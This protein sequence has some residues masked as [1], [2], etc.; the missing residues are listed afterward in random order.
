MLKYDKPKILLMDLG[1]NVGDILRQDGFN[2]AS[3]SFGTPYKVPK[4]AQMQPIIACPTLPNYTEQEVVVVNLMPSSPSDSHFGE[5]NVPSDEWDWWGK[6]S[7]GV[8]DP[9][10]RAMLAV[11]EEMDRIL[12]SGGVF[13]IFADSMVEQDIAIGSIRQGSHF[14]IAR[15]FM[16]SNWS[17]LTILSYLNV[18]DDHGEE[19][20]LV[21]SEAPVAQVLKYHVD[22]A[23][24]SCTLKPGSIGRSQW[25]S[26][27]LNKYNQAVA[28]MI[29]PLGSSNVGWVFIFPNIDDKAGFLGSL[30]K[31]VLP[32]LR[33]Q[34][35]PHAEGD[36]WTRR[37]EY[38]LSSVL[39]K[40]S[41]IERIRV[42]AEQQIAIINKEIESDR[43]SNKFLYEILTG[44]GDKLV[45]AV[46]EALELL[47][48]RAIVDVDAKMKADGNG[49]SLREDLQIQD[50]APILIVDIKGLSGTAADPDA[51]QA[52]KHA[53]VYMAE[54]VGD[55][56][57]PLT[58]INHQRLIPPLERSNDMPFRQ[59]ILDN[60]SQT[61]LG[62]ITT[63]DLFRL[64]RGFL[65]HNWDSA[66]ILPLFYDT[67]RIVPLPRHYKRVGK[68]KQI[69][70]NAFSIDVQ[71]EGF[72]VGD[73]IS[74]VLPVDFEEQNVDSI[75]LNNESVAVA[76]IGSEVGV[77]RE[78]DKQKL[79][80]GALVY[81]ITSQ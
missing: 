15:R 16:C 32:E 81:R 19:I 28:A 71:E 55:R 58:I 47:G 64:V 66:H 9:R 12:D 40:I 7:S 1:K 21:A 42:D 46:I 79:T 44:T 8:I 72:Q 65:R 17:F 5:K 73:R 48:F 36:R 70:R 78:P 14:N 18:V 68:V 25:A 53:Y 38:E 54:N 77:A 61:Y 80:V 41:R 35:F 45:A 49:S 39:D 60:A 34:L 50:C 52:V 4:N 75:K 37:P 29:G 74:I 76:E 13:I 22:K 31:N 20:S 63:W 10:P 57:K 43:T 56:A 51:L 23:V 6:C 69:W 59:E 27:A 30:F 62:L 11:K 2:V 24:F 33:P 3:G 67:G 26:L